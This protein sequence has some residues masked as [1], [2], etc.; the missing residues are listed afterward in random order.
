MFEETPDSFIMGYWGCSRKTAE[1]H[2]KRAIVLGR[3]VAPNVL[4]CCLGF[5]IEVQCSG[6][7]LG[8]QRRTPNHGYDQDSKGHLRFRVCLNVL[9]CQGSPTRLTQTKP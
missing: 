8:L 4:R 3:R 5:R 6:F 2:S 7:P 9:Q 1:A